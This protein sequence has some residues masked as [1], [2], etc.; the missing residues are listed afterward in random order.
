[1]TSFVLSC[2]VFQRRVEHAFSAWLAEQSDAP[3]SIEYAPTE[4]NEPFQLFLRD[5]A[6]GAA[7]EG[8]VTWDAGRYARE[9]FDDL[10]LF[11]LV[12]QVPA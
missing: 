7:A 5:P 10:A 12:T 3:V 4:R 11:E 9:H 8:T 6:F 1:M 2:R